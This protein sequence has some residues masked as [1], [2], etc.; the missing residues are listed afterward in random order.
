MYRI[1]EAAA[2]SGLTVRALRHYHAIGLPQ[3]ATRYR[4]YNYDVRATRRRRWGAP[5]SANRNPAAT[6]RG[7]GLPIGSGGAR[8]ASGGTWNAPACA[9]P[10]RA[11]TP[12]RGS[13]APVSAAGSTTTGTTTRRRSRR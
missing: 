11:P 3:P 5:T 12:C 2:L 1:S 13:A 6:T 4:L 7:A 9:A 8:P 10:S